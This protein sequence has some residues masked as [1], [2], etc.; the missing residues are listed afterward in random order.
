MCWLPDETVFY[1]GRAASATGKRKAFGGGVSAYYRMPLGSDS[2][3]SGGHQIKTLA[4]RGAGRHRAFHSYTMK[5]AIQEGF[6][7]DVLGHYTP[8]ASYYRLAKVVEDDPEY[9]VKTNQPQE[10]RSP[11]NT[12]ATDPRHQG[13]APPTP[14]QTDA[15]SLRQWAKTAGIV[16]NR[17]KPLPADPHGYRHPA[18]R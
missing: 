16:G 3:H 4:D 11:R 14:R 15:A 7:L 13:P 10:S 17:P 12:T 6:I 2:P 18:F 5:Q 9:D 1:L 8:V